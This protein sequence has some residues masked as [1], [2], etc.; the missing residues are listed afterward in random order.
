VRSPLLDEDTVLWLEQL[1]VR[2]AAP[3]SAKAE[4]TMASPRNEATTDETSGVERWL[5]VG[6]PPGLE[7]RAN[8]DE[9]L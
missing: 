5:M 6:K 8:R 7:A 9:V 4:A 2:V 3:S 1:R